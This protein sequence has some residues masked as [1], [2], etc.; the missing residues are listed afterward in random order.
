MS[1]QAEDIA[2][3]SRELHDLDNRVDDNTKNIVELQTNERHTTKSLQRIENKQDKGTL[4][5]MSA[6]ISLIIG[7]ILFAVKLSV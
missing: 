6:L 4:M 1:K 3:L 2:D 7:L 5:I